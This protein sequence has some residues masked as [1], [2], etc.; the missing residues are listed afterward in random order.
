MAQ[1]ITLQL[2]IKLSEHN[3]IQNST[4]SFFFQVSNRKYK[5]IYKLLT[6]ILLQKELTMSVRPLLPNRNVETSTIRRTKELCIIQLFFMSNGNVVELNVIDRATQ[7]ASDTPDPT[8]QVQSYIY[9]YR[10]K[11]FQYLPELSSKLVINRDF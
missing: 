1:N 9:L 3:N 8:E 4:M 6:L 10:T 2:S 5:S 7:T 11:T